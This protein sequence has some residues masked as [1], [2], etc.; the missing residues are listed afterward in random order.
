M[1]ALLL[2]LTATGAVASPAAA[3]PTV[4]FSAK[5]V[6]IV[7]F[8]HTGNIARTGA[9]LKLEYTISGTEDGGNPPPL[10]AIRLAFPEGLKVMQGW[11]SCPTTLPEGQQPEA[12]PRASRAGPPGELTAVVEPAG[13]ETTVPLLPVVVPGGLALAP[14]GSPE[15]FDLSGSFVPGST[16]PGETPV[17]TLSLPSTSIGSSSPAFSVRRLAVEIGSALRIANKTHYYLRVPAGCQNGMHPDSVLTFAQDGDRSRPLTV[18]AVATMPCP[19]QP[20]IAQAPSIAPV[21]PPAPPP[22]RSARR[23]T[24]HID[25][26]SGLVFRQVRVAVDGRNVNV[27]R[28]GRDTTA[29]VDLRGLPKGTYAVRVIATTGSGRRI[30]L[31]RHYRTCATGG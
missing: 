14:E 11:P 19:R 13:T 9:A 21:V 6:P 17:L 31:T 10:T 3:V 16:E 4:A 26:P 29:I 8:P 28:R 1:G 12:C 24:I 7:G 27:R 15:G 22:C 5:L 30:V 20:T 2:G 25:P 23:F 18:D